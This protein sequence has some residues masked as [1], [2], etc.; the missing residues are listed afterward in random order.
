MPPPV[1]EQHWWWF[2]QV[3]DVLLDFA[4]DPDNI[5][6]RM[7]QINVAEDLA[8]SLHESMKSIRSLYPDGIAPELMKAATKVDHVLAAKSLGGTAF[9]EDFWTNGAFGRHPDWVQ[10]REICR[11]FLLK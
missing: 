11:D 7:G 9:E 6:S 10:I 8:C 5:L 1:E 2:R 4:E 3:H